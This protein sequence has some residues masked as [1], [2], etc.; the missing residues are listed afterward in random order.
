MVAGL[1]RSIICMMKFFTRSELQNAGSLL[2][3]FR[4]GG[5]KL[6]IKELGHLSNHNYLVVPVL[7]SKPC[8]RVSPINRNSQDHGSSTTLCEM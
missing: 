2:V 8:E 5:G 7:L 4:S 1:C 3:Y 6:R